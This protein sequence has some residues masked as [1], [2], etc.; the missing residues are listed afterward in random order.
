MTFDDLA[1]ASVTTTRPASEDG[2]GR[3]SGSDS[4]VYDGA[5]DVQEETVEQR[6][7]DGTVYVVGEATM[8]PPGAVTS[9]WLAQEEGDTV[10]IT[11]PDGGEKTGTIAKG[12]RRLDGR[13]VLSYTTE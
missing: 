9:T 8:F 5:A 6:T 1:T 2:L 3:A 13:V 10:A 12:P 7:R 4:T 11:F